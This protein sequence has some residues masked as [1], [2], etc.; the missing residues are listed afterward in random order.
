MT[1]FSFAAQPLACEPSTLNPQ[2]CTLNPEPCILNQV[3]KPRDP[4]ADLET[5]RS[6]VPRRAQTPTSSPT[7]L[8]PPSCL[9]TYTSHP[10]P[11]PHTLYPTPYTLHPTPYNLHPAHCTIHPAP[12]TLNPQR[13]PPLSFCPGKEAQFR[14]D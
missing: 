10:T 2:P 6:A 13:S 1:G 12:C 7:S 11:K 8:I 4:D 9:H 14:R 3:G 5:G